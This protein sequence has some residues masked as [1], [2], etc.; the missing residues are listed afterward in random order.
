MAGNVY[1]TVQVLSA[2]RIGSA[3]SVAVT[4]AVSSLSMLGTDYPTSSITLPAAISGEL[5]TRTN[6]TQGIVTKTDHGLTNETIALFWTDPDDGTDK[7]AY[8]CEITSYDDDTITFT[9]GDGDVLPDGAIGTTPG[10]TV[11]V[12]VAQYI[13]D[14]DIPGD[15][16]LL[17]LR[18]QSG[19]DGWCNLY[20]SSGTT[21]SYAQLE[22][23]VSPTSPYIWPVKQDEAIPLAAAVQYALCYNGAT[24]ASTMTIEGIVE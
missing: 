12:A 17:M 10:T 15:S 6:D 3:A 14:L 21:Q 24:V 23:W 2:I 22:T 19:N 5:T 11:K 7:C 9:V 8:D 13:D 18:I 16:T 1:G 20:S 4:P